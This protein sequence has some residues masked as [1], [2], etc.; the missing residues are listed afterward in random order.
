MA[1]IVFAMLFFSFFF[2]TVG[3]GWPR[4]MCLVVLIEVIR[5]GHLY[6]VIEAHFGPKLF[7][8]KLGGVTALKSFVSSR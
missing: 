7:R 1:F 4:K 2:Q 3:W 8:G 5:V 6:D